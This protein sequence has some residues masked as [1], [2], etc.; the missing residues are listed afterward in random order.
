MKIMAFWSNF[1]PYHLARLNALACL[2][3]VVGV[4]IAG[5]ERDR[6]WRTGNDHIDFKRVTLFKDVVFEDIKERDRSS[7]CIGILNAENPDVVLTPGYS[8]ASK[9][10]FHE[11]NDAHKKC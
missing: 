2:F 8:I 10:I 7:K 6:E 11:T 5:V 4:E 1:G 3:H 9:Q